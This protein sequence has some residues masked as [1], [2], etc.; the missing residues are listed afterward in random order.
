MEE[1]NVDGKGRVRD[2]LDVQLRQDFKHLFG[3]LVALGRSM[4][5]SLHRANYGRL[6]DLKAKYDP[7][8]VFY[9]NVSIRPR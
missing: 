3:R 5:M 2:L 6:R 7:E 8:S 1:E 9:V 4:G